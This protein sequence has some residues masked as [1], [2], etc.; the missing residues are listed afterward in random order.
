MF[1]IPFYATDYASA[2]EFWNWS[3][4]ISAEQILEQIAGYAIDNVEHLKQIS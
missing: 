3:P 4:T 2:K 1:D